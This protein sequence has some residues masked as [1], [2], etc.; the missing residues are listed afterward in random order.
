LI[1][2]SYG[3]VDAGY[4]DD[5]IQFAMDDFTYNATVPEPSTLLLFGTGLIGIG[6]FR[7]KFKG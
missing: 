4:G 7:R 3:G 6:I 1:I 5:W 2:S